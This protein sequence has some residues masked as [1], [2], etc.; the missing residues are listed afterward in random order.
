M[1]EVKVM[2]RPAAIYLSLLSFDVLG[3][4]GYISLGMHLDFG[5]I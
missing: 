5:R 1:I 3:N 2:K 4:L